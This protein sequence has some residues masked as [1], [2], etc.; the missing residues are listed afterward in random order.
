MGLIRSEWFFLHIL[1]QH[2][3]QAWIAQ[4][5]RQELVERLRDALL[6]VLQAMPHRPV[7]YRSFDF[8][9]P[10][11]LSHA[12]L[13]APHGAASPSLLNHLCDPAVFDLELEVLKQLCHYSGHGASLR[14]LLPFVRTPEEVAC[15]Q[16]Q[17]QQVFQT[18]RSPLP[19]WIM[20]EVP[21][22]L[23]LL[24][25]YRD[26]GVQG[27]VVG[28]NDL[29]RLLMGLDRES[30]HPNLPI[31]LHYPTVQQAIATIIE[32]VRAL[33]LPC[34]VAAPGVALNREIV[35]QWVRAG[36]TAISVEGM[37]IEQ[38]RYWLMQTEQE[39]LLALMRDRRFESSGDRKAEPP[40]L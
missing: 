5:R 20:A 39:M 34:V 28:C 32:G 35:G 24:E 9:V 33:G 30:T 10:E 8:R 36:V 18:A 26:V 15:R 31:P 6:P 21:S 37:A 13:P 2:S 17:I 3:P 19:L 12:P 38:L 1:D 27:F 23:F 29:G 7:F 16:Y 14:L 40:E 25:A 22:V 11:L 4:G